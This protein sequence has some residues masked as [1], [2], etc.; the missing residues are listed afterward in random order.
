MANLRQSYL[1]Q[2]RT[3]L[4]APVSGYIAKRNAQVGQRV[5]AGT[6]LM[7]VVPLDQVWVDANFKETQMERDAYCFRPVT[8]VSDLLW[9]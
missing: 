1:Y 7:T 2:Q 3:K 6:A 5:N 4:I 8:L 9:G